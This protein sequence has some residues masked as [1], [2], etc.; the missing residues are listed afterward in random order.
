LAVSS[1]LK[2]RTPS[3][4]PSRTAL[5]SALRASGRSMVNQA[6]PLRTW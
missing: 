2:V 1:A 4:K 6:T 5:F 3:N